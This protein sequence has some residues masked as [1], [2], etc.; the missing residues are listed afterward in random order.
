MSSTEKY[1]EDVLKALRKTQRHFS[2]ETWP[3]PKIESLR[4]HLHKSTDNTKEEAKLIADKLIE[5][6]FV[7]VEEQDYD[8]DTKLISLDIEGFKDYIGYIEP[9]ELSSEELSKIE[10]SRE[11][12]EWLVLERKDIKT[13][14]LDPARNSKQIW[15]YDKDVKI[16]KKG[17]EDKL[18]ELIY[19]EI[20][21]EHSQYLENEV[22]TKVYRI[23]P[24]H[25]DQT[26][27]EEA[28]IP[29]KNGILKLGK[30]EL[31]D[32]KRK[33]NNT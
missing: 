23:E 19:E 33:N 17:G 15:Y 6:H 25:I 27:T 9:F 8:E 5:D 12:A 31:K 14:K 22:K 3:S 30:D 20:P 32:I 2:E 21:D 16:W 10:I 26:G 4:I 24:I 1:S 29:V 7:E 28:E 11:F 13:V 18:A